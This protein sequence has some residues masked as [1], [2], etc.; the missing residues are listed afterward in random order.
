MPRR[1]PAPPLAALRLAACF[2]ALGGLAALATL[3]APARAGQGDI[4][5][6]SLPEGL[7]ASTDSLVI[8][9]AEATTCQ[10]EI[11]P[12][13]DA[14]LPLA[15]ASGG[16]GR[17][18]FVPAALAL[19]AGAW[20]AR[21][22][23]ANGADSSLPFI[24]FSEAETAPRMIAPQNGSEIPAGGAMLRWEPVLGVPYYHVLFSDQEIVI[25]ENEEGDPVIAGAAIV[26]QAITSGTAIAYGDVDPSGFFTAMN[27]VSPPLV[28]GAEYNWL[29]LNNYAANPALSS[30]RQAGVS[31]FRVAAS[32][33]PAPTLLAPAAGDSLSAPSLAFSWSAVPEASHYQF[34]LSRLID[35]DGNEG[36][37]GVYDQITGQPLLDLP[38]A[39]LLVESRYRWKVYAIDEAGHGAASLPSEFSYRIAM[40]RLAVTTRNAQGQALPFVQLT[41]TPLGGGGSSLPVVTGGSGG[42]DDELV[43]GSYLVAAGKDGYEPASAEVSVLAGATST[44]TLSLAASPATLAGSVRDQQQQP[45]PY[46][47]VSARNTQTG[48]LRQV[49]ASAGGAFAL[50]VDAG[51][52]RLLAARSGYHVA[53]SMLVAAA[54]GAYVTLPAAL[55]LAPNASTLSG[56]VRNGSGQPLLAATVTASKGGE[57]L[58]SLTGADGQFQFSVDAGTWSLTAAKTGYVSPAPRSLSLAPGDQLAV[59]PPL[60]LSAQA[61]I[62][63]GFV[64]AAGGLVGGALVTATP[65]TGYAHYATAGAQGSWQ[66]SLPAG[67]WSF[68]A[69]KP[70]YAPAPLQLTLAPGGA[71]RPRPRA[72]GQSL[73]GE[74]A[75]HGRR[76]APRGRHAQRRRAQHHQRLGRPLQPRPRR[77]QPQPAGLQDR[78]QRRRPAAHAGARPAADGPGLHAR[79]RRRHGERSRPGPGRARGR[80][81]GQ[82]G[83]RHP[84]GRAQQRRRRQLHAERPARQLHARRHEEH[85][86]GGPSLALTLAAGQTLPDQLLQLTPAGA[87]LSG[88]VLVGGAPLRD[89]QLLAV[90]DLGSSPTSSA[91]GRQLVPARGRRRRLDPERRQGGPCHGDGSRT[92]A[93]RWRRLES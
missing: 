87:R 66:L 22:V 58:Q 41:L 85:D 77:R 20:A 33:L 25:E 12:A 54:A 9:W 6:T 2:T 62:L 57:S 46:A 53:D 83:R 26:W 56:S 36:A 30:T 43:P 60:A 8:R 76:P 91:A 28:A 72:H 42:W 45:L 67:T 49:L 52:W 48:A 64:E 74:R 35:E 90:S 68:A 84:H 61:A 44:L 31:A 38:A 75:G 5:P 63:S 47:L 17:L 93:R 10:L 14:L 4:H 86:A 39:S 71:E 27:G 82:P 80:G 65:T 18:A 3:A 32:D 13:P 23:S 16:P 92:R 88:R 89:A 37:V 11:G 79:P 50:G 59:D 34:L 51:T 7:V 69:S 21:L 70:G 78:L 15:G 24:V 40:G 73:P 81:A 19:G 1:L 55:H 29:V